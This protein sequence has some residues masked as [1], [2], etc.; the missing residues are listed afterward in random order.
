MLPAKIL[1]GLASVQSKQ[2][3]VVCKNPYR[4]PSKG[5]DQMSFRWAFRLNY[6]V[7]LVHRAVP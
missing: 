3:S 5:S 2:F 6:Y 1:T 7:P 4:A